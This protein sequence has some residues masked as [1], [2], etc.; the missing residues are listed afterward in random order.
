M[1]F[2]VEMMELLEELRKKLALVEAYWYFVDHGADAHD[3]GLARKT[4]AKFQGTTAPEV[5]YLIG[6]LNN[7]FKAGRE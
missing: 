1:P 5:V 6:E 4:L 7:I 3:C 2:D